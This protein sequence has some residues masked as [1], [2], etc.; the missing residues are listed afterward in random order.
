MGQV[1]RNSGFARNHCSENGLQ[2]SEVVAYIGPK[3]AADKKN[4]TKPP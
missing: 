1:E 4:C 2:W 3:Y